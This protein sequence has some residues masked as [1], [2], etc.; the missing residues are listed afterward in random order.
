M[1]NTHYR[2][3]NV[4]LFLRSDS[5]RYQARCKL[6]NGKWKR[7]ATGENNI[8]KASRIACDKYDELKVLSKRK[9]AFDTR[10]F[11][12]V[13]KLAI[14]EMETELDAGY[15][16]KSFVDYI[17]ALGNYFIPYFGNINIDTIDYKKLKEFD[18]WR[19]NKVGR[20]LSH[21]AINNHNSGLKRVFKVAVDR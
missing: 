15:G 19:I 4:V 10:R 11:S 7:F 17:S 9:I 8:K 2:D 6:P 13:A 14:R 1:K 5:E 21:S 16:K 3:G 20:V 12:D 18:E